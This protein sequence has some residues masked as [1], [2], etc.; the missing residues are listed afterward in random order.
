M[1][2]A[3]W[4][5]ERPPT[6]MPDWG[7]VGVRGLMRLV[8]MPYQKDSLFEDADNIMVA[9]KGKEKVSFPCKLKWT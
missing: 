3:T 7:A 4:A 6:S 2:R 9:R 1:K 8:V 5:N